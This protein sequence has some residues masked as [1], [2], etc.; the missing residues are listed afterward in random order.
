MVA[1]ANFYIVGRDPAGMP[2]PETG[3][4]LYEPSHGAKV[5]TMAPGLITL[6][7]VP[8]RVAAYNK[9]KK[10]MD[11]YDSEQAKNPKLLDPKHH[12]RDMGRQRSCFGWR[13]R[14]SRHRSAAALRTKRT[15]L[16]ALLNRQFEISEGR[17]AY[18][19][20]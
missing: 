20:D 12:L 14:F 11:Y 17:L 3:K 2:H 4:D 16:G 18:S 9:K 7:I 8:F 13:G 5:L 15:A 10:R 6:E 19:S 1:G